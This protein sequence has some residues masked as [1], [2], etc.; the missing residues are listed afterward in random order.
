LRT[1][2]QRA[3][4]QEQQLA[5]SAEAGAATARA[6]AA[7]RQCLALEEAAVKAT[8]EMAR[9]VMEQQERE[10]AA[11]SVSSERASQEAFRAEEAE[12]LRVEAE[13]RAAKLSTLKALTIEQKEA[14]AQKEAL[15]QER[16]AELATLTALTMEQK[17]ALAQ[18][19]ALLQKR[20]STPDRFTLIHPATLEKK[21]SFKDPSDPLSR[22]PSD[23]EIDLAFAVP[24]NAPTIMKT[25]VTMVKNLNDGKDA[26]DGIN[27]VK[28]EVK[29]SK[30]GK[31][32]VY[33]NFLGYE[34]KNR[35][36]YEKNKKRFIQVETDMVMGVNNSSYKTPD[37]DILVEAVQKSTGVPK[38]SIDKSGNVD[39]MSIQKKIS[40]YNLTDYPGM[41]LAT[42][43]DPLLDKLKVAVE[44]YMDANRGSGLKRKAGAGAGGRGRKKTRCG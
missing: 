14:L 44:K 24:S 11:V 19:E 29:L 27:N 41:P 25:I 40:V 15:L 30:G 21:I 18:K 37:L 34:I 4:A 5:A 23:A 28:V 17:E 7:A 32:D 22:K 6:L 38:L 43:I 42:Y 13:A 16:K 2:E 33:T 1:L 35:K 31:R 8:A 9:Q 3:A 20:S 39:E 10:A 36:D 26:Y 12:R